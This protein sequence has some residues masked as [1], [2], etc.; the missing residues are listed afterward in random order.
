MSTVYTNE[1]SLSFW[2]RL[3]RARTF[4]SSFVVKV[5]ARRPRFFVNKITGYVMRLTLRLLV[6]DLC[7]GALASAADGQDTQRL[8]YGTTNSIMNLPVWVAQDARLF[9]KHGLTNVEI[10]FIQSGTWITMG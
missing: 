5:A 6:F 4:V 1:T 8:R 3:C 7:V 2:L 9:S 10:I